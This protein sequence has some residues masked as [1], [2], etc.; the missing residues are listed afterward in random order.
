MAQP[1][2]ARPNSV[3]DFGDQLRLGPYAAVSNAPA[4]GLPGPLQLI[5]HCAQSF[6]V[7]ALE[8]VL[9]LAR[10][11][12]SLA[13]PPTEIEPVEAPFLRF[14]AG[15]RERFALCAAQ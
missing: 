9:D 12:Q 5:E 1:S 8:S 11:G 3:F 13:F 2:I 7:R 6:R 15:D 10:I 14:V 4:E